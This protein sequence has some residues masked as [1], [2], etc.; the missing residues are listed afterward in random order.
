MFL[1][2][3][4]TI[5]QGLLEVG[6]H[7]F[8]HFNINNNIFYSKKIQAI[9]PLQTIVTILTKSMVLDNSVLIH[10]QKNIHHINVERNK[11]CYKLVRDI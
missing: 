11:L 9:E 10:Q 5:E 7:E 8:K 3:H 6:L 4:L 2:F 1:L